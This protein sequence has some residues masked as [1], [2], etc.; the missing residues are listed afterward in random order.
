MVGERPLIDRIIDEEVV[1]SSLHHLALGCHM[2]C[3]DEEVV[4]PVSYDYIHKPPEE[5]RMSEKEE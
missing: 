2:C 1:C 5:V 3:R 4:V